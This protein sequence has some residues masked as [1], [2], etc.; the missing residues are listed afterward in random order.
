MA[1]RTSRRLISCQ[2]GFQM[3]KLPNRFTAKEL[4][5]WSIARP[6]PGGWTPAEPERQEPSFLDLFAWLR[7]IEASALVF[8]GKLDVVVFYPHDQRTVWGKNGSVHVSRLDGK[9][10]RGDLIRQ[11]DNFWEIATKTDACPFGL[12][13]SGIYKAVY[14]VRSYFTRS[15]IFIEVRP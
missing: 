9:V 7:R 14:W 4:K 15:P 10:H 3:I 2:G 1:L 6:A 11:G 13:T 5:N 12:R 8:M